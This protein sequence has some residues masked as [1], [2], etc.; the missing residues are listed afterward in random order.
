M[1]RNLLRGARGL[2]S[3]L[4]ALIAP[5]L[6]EAADGFNAAWSTGS[7][8]SVAFW[9]Y[10]KDGT[11]ESRK[12][13]IFAAGTREGKPGAPLALTPKDLDFCLLFV[14]ADKSE[15]CAGGSFEATYDSA[16]NAY[17][18]KYELNFKHAKKTSGE[19]RAQ[20]CAAKRP[21]KQ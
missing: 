21:A 1:K 9:I 18:G 6:A 14:G 2:F 13:P 7:K 15:N 3:A 5:C 17:R 16:Q 4:I 12:D 19:F 20:Y 8:G 10:E 11:C